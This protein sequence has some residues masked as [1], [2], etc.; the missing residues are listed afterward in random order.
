MPRGTLAGQLAAMG[1]ADTA[2][3][4]ALIA[5]LGLA[6]G[7]DGTVLQDAGAA[8][9]AP[10]AAGAVPDGHPGGG[11]NG[12]GATGGADLALLRAVA[13]AADPDLA[14]A[15][16]A[17][18]DPDAELRQ[19]LRDD[20]GLRDRLTSVLGASAA[21]GDHLAR[22]PADWRLLAGETSFPAAD[23]AAG[24]TGELL[25]AVGASLAPRRSP[26]RRRRATRARRPGCGSPTGAGCSSWRHWT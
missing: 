15:A 24:L 13:A 2:R 11:T 21:L 4:R 8:R 25:A 3:A 18:L 23:A 17:R 14:L 1:F 16:L 20:A 22:H 6:V 9:P 19:A 10:E 26:A 12:G 5:G 7:G